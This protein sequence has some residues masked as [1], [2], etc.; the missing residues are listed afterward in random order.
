MAVEK[1]IIEPAANGFI[2]SSQR[3]AKLIAK[4]K[5]EL[6][7]IIAEE[8]ATAIDKAMFGNSSVELTISVETIIIP[9]NS[10]TNE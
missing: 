8:T 1:L 9:Q 10:K 7:K 4:T 3:G 6:A 2:A 5:E